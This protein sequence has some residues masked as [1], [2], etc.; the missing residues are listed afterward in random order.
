MRPQPEGVDRPALGRDRQTHG[1]VGDELR[2]RRARDVV[3]RH[4]AVPR[5]PVRLQREQVELQRRVDRDRVAEDKAERAAA[6]ERAG[7]CPPTPCRRQR[8]RRSGSPRPSLADDRVGA[9]IDPRHARR[10]EVRHPDEA[11]GDLDRRRTAADRDCRDDRAASASILETVKSSVFTT[12]TASPSTAIAEGPF[13]TE[14]VAT[15]SPD[16]GRPRRPRSCRTPRPRSFRSDRERGRLTCRSSVRR[17][18]P[19]AGSISISARSV[20]SATQSASS[21]PPNASAETSTPSLSVCVTVPVS[22]STRETLPSGIARN[23]DRP[24]PTASA[25]GLPPTGMRSPIAPEP[26]SILATLPALGSA[27]Q[28]GRCRCDSGGVPG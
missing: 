6:A 8:K 9:G 3:V 18:A 10:V 5:Q 15:V 23:P 4:E 13:P 1:Q 24:P 17:T 14:I 25:P 19:E 28:S 20:A 11:A 21:P 27:S 16:G 26:R 12:Q 2:S 7:A 22:G